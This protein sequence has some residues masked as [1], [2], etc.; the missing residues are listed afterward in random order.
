M[1][2]TFEGID[3][4][5][6]S[7]QV[8]LLADFLRKQHFPVEIVRDPGATPISEAIRAIL[9]NPQFK[10]MNPR[11]ELLLYAAA[12]SQLTA[13]FIRP[14]LEKGGIVLSDRY[15]DSTTAY[16]GFGRELD[17]DLIR[18]LNAIGA[19]ELQPDLTF[20][21]DMAIEQADERLINLGKADRME[22]ESLAFKTRVR[23]AFRQIAEYEPNRC[24]LIPGGEGIEENFVRIRK[25]TMEKLQE[26][27]GTTQK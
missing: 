9:L 17:P 23:N 4:S 10:E 16:Q 22:Q 25:I 5:G 1:F 12:R 18:T 19:H 8:N 7:T 21:M 6:K 27:Y 3:G 24:H 13:Q 2:I 26:K 15:Y 20:I 11:T 14:F